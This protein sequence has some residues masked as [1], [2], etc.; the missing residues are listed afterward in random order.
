MLKDKANTLL[1]VHT[2]EI[3][4]VTLV[5]TLFLCV[6][7]G[8]GI[9][10]NVAF[11]VF[12]GRVKMDQLYSPARIICRDDEMFNIYLLDQPEVS[13]SVLRNKARAREPMKR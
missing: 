11:G 2:E 3:R 7:A 8:Q 5:A 10:E 6:Q 1:K 13:V 9:G 4:M 12:L